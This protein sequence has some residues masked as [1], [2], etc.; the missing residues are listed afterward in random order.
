MFPLRIHVLHPFSKA[1]KFYKATYISFGLELELDWGMIYCHLY[2]KD[3]CVTI[4]HGITMG[5]HTQHL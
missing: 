1:S 4:C 5:P 2:K 3:L